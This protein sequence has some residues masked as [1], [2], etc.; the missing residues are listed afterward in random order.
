MFAAP[1]EMPRKIR[2]YCRATAQTE[3][4]TVGETLRCVYQ[5]LACEFSRTLKSISEVTGTEY[6]RVYMVGGGTKDKLLCS[7]TADICEK[8]VVAGPAEAAALGNGISSLIAMGEIQ[9]VKA[10]R[11]AIISSGLT[12]TYTPK[13]DEKHLFERYMKLVSR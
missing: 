1:G 3:P 13:P 12:V 8:P 5:S 11:A 6:E 9:S 2:D 10:A 7:L 4:C